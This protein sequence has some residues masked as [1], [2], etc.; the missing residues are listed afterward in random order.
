MWKKDGTL[1]TTWTGGDA[2]LL[3]D[4][5]TEV[6][7]NGNPTEVGTSGIGYLD[8]IAAEMN[9]DCVTIKATVT[10]TDAVPTIITLY[11]EA[12]GDINVDVTAYGGGAVPV[13]AATGV[14]DVNVTHIN[15][16]NQAAITQAKALSII[17]TGTAKTGGTQTTV[18]V[19]SDDIDAL[20]ANDTRVVG[21]TL[22]VITEAEK[23]TACRISGYAVSAGTATITLN[24]STPLQAALDPGD[25]FII[26]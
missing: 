15:D 13:P 10:N 5:A 2:V 26:I 19:Q 11:P 12:T 16:S 23:Y 25:E 18:S 17:P 9:Y 22:Y 8:L 14:P 21:R 3:K 24:A 6:Q 1:I 7:A 4:D 20:V